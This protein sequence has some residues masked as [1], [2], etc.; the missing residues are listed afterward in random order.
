VGVNLIAVNG[1][2]IP[3]AHSLEDDRSL[4]VGAG[5]LE[6]FAQVGDEALKGRGGGRRRLLAPQFVDEPVGRHHL[7]GVQYQ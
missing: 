4:T 7:A 3:G 6:K 5:R 2:D 1:Q